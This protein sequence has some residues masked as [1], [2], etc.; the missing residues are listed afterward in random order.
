MLAVLQKKHNRPSLCAK[1]SNKPVC[2]ADGPPAR[3][4]SQRHPSLQ[5][6]MSPALQ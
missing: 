3:R 6:R 5:F 1:L 2:Q 4:D